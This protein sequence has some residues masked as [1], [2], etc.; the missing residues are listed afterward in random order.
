MDSGL[1]ILHRDPTYNLVGHTQYQHLQSSNSTL[2]ATEHHGWRFFQPGGFCGTDR[3]LLP[4]WQEGG[5]SACLLEPTFAV[6]IYT[7]ITGMI[8]Y[9]WYRIRR[10]TDEGPTRAL[11]DASLIF[12]MRVFLGFLGFLHLTLL[13]F[14]L[15]GNHGEGIRLYQFPQ[16]FLMAIVYFKVTRMMA[17][18]Y[19][20]DRKPGSYLPTLL[21]LAFLHAN[22]ELA[23]VNSS[24]YFDQRTQVGVAE[25]SIF[26]LRYLGLLFVGGY[27]IILVMR[28]AEDGLGEY[29][30]L[31]VSADGANGAGPSK[32]ESPWKDFGAKMRRLMPYLWPRDKPLLQIYAFIAFMTLVGGRIVNVLVPIFYKK[33]IDDLTPGKDEDYHDLHFP[34]GTLIAFIVIRF[35]QGGGIGSMGLL[36]GIRS[37]FWV[38]ISQY[39]TRTMRVGL[40]EHLQYMSLRWHLGRK[41]GEVLRIMDRGTDSISSLM[42]SLIFNIIPTL[43]DIGLG[44]GFFAIYFDLYFGA[45]VFLTMAA[46]LWFTIR[47][48]EWRTK[49]RRAM[50]DA[51]NA[52]R[53]KAVDALLNF[54][55]V[56]YYAGEKFETN[57]LDTAIKKYQAVEWDTQTSL[58]LLNTGQSVIIT[59]GLL[60]G[61][62]L[63]TV[64]ILQ[65]RFTVGDFVLFLSYVGQMYSPLNW[66]GTYYRVIQQYFIDMQNMFDLMDLEPEVQDAPD[67][68]T[69]QVSKG[70][71]EFKNVSFDYGDRKVLDNVSFEIPPGQTFALVGPSGAGKS[72]IIRLLFR[73]YDT[74]DGSIIIDGQDIRDVTQESLRMNCGVVPQD[75]VLF[76]DTVFYNIQYGRRDAPY[77]E[78]INAAKDA[79]IHAK[80]E[81]FAEGYDTVVGERG[82]RLS[83][84]EKQRVAIARTLLKN[85][86]IVLLDEAT[87]ALDTETERMIQAQL[88]RVT[89]GRTTLVVAHRLSTV[90]GADQI[91]V[92]RDGKIAERGSHRELLA[93]DGIYAGMWRQ[94]LE[95]Q[96]EVRE[97]SGKKTEAEKE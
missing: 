42:S 36:N 97:A 46:Y 50:N 10:G 1:R 26:G 69:L 49:F 54:E 45:L 83:G 88:N 30:P 6:V 73:F 76:H 21:S 8:L 29:A 22:L 92:L 94:Q 65:G 38:Q 15:F 2:T 95:A 47:V 62:I 56:K 4:I 80:V 89:E 86:P 77:D 5:F 71:I 41:T 37:L 25:T 39:T 32:P 53:T 79:E 44:I 93:S 20:N 23:S 90:I 9:R 81:T 84:G 60:A 28:R 74:K 16:E 87:S 51:D 75:T 31:S 48:T 34:T 24:E 11:P 27:Y 55:T 59:V 70:H 72:T 52:T 19:D 40:F 14:R 12:W 85:P 64:R 58:T 96:D 17:Y 68:K 7:I 43:V 63:C 3:S 33:L 91:L 82:L 78:V 13:T 35:L 61:L 67:A 66:F 57:R 18:E